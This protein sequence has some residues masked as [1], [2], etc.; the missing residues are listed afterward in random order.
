MTADWKAW[1]ERFGWELVD[2]RR[3]GAEFRVPS[4]DAK[5]GYEYVTIT[6]TVRVNIDDAIE[7]AVEKAVTSACDEL[8][9][10][11]GR[12]ASDREAGR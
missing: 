3:Y 11:I 6:E 12:R 9:R 1:G 4:I 10:Q 8:R 2:A 5:L 7:A